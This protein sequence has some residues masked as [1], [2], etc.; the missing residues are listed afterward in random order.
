VQVC[1]DDA[2]G[3]WEEEQ[4]QQPRQQRD[5]QHTSLQAPLTAC[6]HSQLSQGTASG[7]QQ[8][9]R[10]NGAEA[11]WIGN[12]KRKLPDSEGRE[13]DWVC[14]AAAS[15]TP[16]SQGDTWA[17]F[18]APA[19]DATHHTGYVRDSQ[20]AGQRARHDQAAG[21]PFSTRA[22]APPAEDVAD[23]WAAL[24][25]EAAPFGADSAALTAG[26]SPSA[27]LTAA[28]AGSASPQCQA[29]S[30]AWP[31][32]TAMS[33][34]AGCAAAFDDDLGGGWGCDVVWEDCA[35]DDCMAP[36]AL[37]QAAVIPSHPQAAAAAGTAN[38]WGA[39]PQL[40]SGALTTQDTCDA[41]DWEYDD[42]EEEVAAKPAA[43]AGRLL[44]ARTPSSRT[45]AWQQPGP[46]CGAELGKRRHEEIGDRIIQAS[47]QAHVAH[48]CVHVHVSAPHTE[49][50]PVHTEWLAPI[51]CICRM[52]LLSFTSGDYAATM[53][54]P[55]HRCRCCCCRL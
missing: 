36:A 11:I 5:Q 39:E 3:Q 30:E 7:W 17:E 24:E 44:L 1:F 37:Q 50:M 53:L 35:D 12:E 51:A 9:E 48:D 41:L 16:A 32:P 47:R 23:P 18:E 45:A 19:R 33:A 10:T 34:A 8:G 20:E 38:S 31:S 25:A 42:A 29:M 13:E 52:R 55:L 43:G 4:Q 40:D 15:S 28:A 27:A 14:A 2:E 21:S 26:T 49:G 46:G 54:L 22:A 6:R